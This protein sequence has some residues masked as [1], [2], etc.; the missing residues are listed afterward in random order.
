MQETGSNKSDSSKIVSIQLTLNGH[1]FRDILQTIEGID[2][3][4]PCRIKITADTSKTVLVPLKY[5]KQG[6]EAN[7][8]AIN[9]KALTDE[10][11]AVTTQMDDI[12]AIM[13]VD[14]QVAHHLSKEWKVEYHTPIFD[15]IMPFAKTVR[16]LTTDENCYFIVCNDTLQYADVFAENE[17]ENIAFIASK[18][19]EA[20]GLKRYEVRIK[21]TQ[22]ET[23]CA[24]LKGIFR[25]CDII[26]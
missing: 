5:F 1:N 6:L 21:G 4:M 20:M 8:L 18:L 22:D 9:D 13:A 26:R 10:E 24:L 3:T 2:S 14:A 15:G 16:I 23:I 19:S 25:N 11:T 12:V 17:P 7:Y